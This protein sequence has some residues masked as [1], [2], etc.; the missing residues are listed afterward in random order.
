[1]YLTPRFTAPLL[2]AACFTLSVASAPASET[3]HFDC[4]GNGLSISVTLEPEKGMATV[5]SPRGTEQLSAESDGV[6]R[7]AAQELQFYADEMPPTLWMGSEQ[8]SCNPVLAGATQ[9][10]VSG[11]V[12][13]N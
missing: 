12:G 5:V 1:M 9:T 3:A 11:A 4:G 8:I 13:C 2:A 10:H 6:W 7:D